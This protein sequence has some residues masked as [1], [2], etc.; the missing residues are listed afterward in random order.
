[1]YDN[2]NLKFWKINLNQFAKDHLMT[3][4]ITFPELSYYQI[5][6]FM[7]IRT[8]KKHKTSLLELFSTFVP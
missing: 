8:Q 6:L 4:E 7:N 3:W 5:L 1:M 2:F